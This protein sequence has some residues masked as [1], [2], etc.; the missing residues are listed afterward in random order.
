MN[1]TSLFGTYRLRKL[2]VLKSTRIN[3]LKDF[4]NL[5]PTD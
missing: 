1:I 2:V 3:G 5:A 4:K